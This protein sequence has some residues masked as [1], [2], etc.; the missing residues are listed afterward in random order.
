MK[1]KT[2]MIENKLK[3]V[4]ETMLITL[5]AKAQESKRADA[6]LRDDKA[7]EIISRL[8][9]DFSR[10][11]KA[12][13]SQ[14]GV[15]LRASLIDAEV[16]AYLGKHPD[17][18][19]VQLGAGLDARYERLRPMGVTHWY[20]LDLEEAIAL[21]RQLLSETERNTYI[22]SSMFDY[23]WMEIA[24]AHGKP[25]LIIIEGV[26][27]YF[28]PEEVKAFFLALCNQLGHATVLF[29]MLAFSLVGRSQHHDSVRKI[30]SNA[31]FR[32]S[33]LST[34]DMEAWHPNLQVEKE[35]YMSEHDQGRYPLLFRLL[36]KIPYFF[37]H[38]NQR[39]VR[40][41]IG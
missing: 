4:P 10:F 5:W 12:K 29:D 27:M 37:R 41:R 28:A 25:V 3:D 36:Y 6:L 35:Y 30:G 22:V 17:A 15:C 32:W 13:F 40:L 1:V 24:R 26:L 20:D 33:L 21:R 9:Y 39:V 18:V 7:T 11:D 8:D 19:V 31:E 23:G 2:A 14:V 38:F 16:R 34:K